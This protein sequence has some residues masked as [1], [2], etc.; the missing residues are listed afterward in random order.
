M[1][2]NFLLI[3]AITLFLASGCATIKEDNSHKSKNPAI[4]RLNKQFIGFEHGM[5]IGGWLTNYKRFNVL[6][7]K[8]KLNLSPGDYEHFETYITRNDVQNIASFGMDH[9]RLGF[10]QIVL[11]EKP[12]VYRERTFRLIDNFISWCREYKIN[13]VLN[14][15]KAIGNYC[16]IPEPVSLMDDPELQ[17]RFIALWLEFERR[18]H[19]NN[20]IVF[21]L[22]NEVRNVNPKLWNSLAERTIQTIRKVNPTRKIVI[23]STAWNSCST[24]KDLQIFDDEN[25]IYTFHIYEPFEFTHQRG[26]LQAAPL[27]Y[28]R[29]MA[30]PSDIAP[31]REFKKFVGNSD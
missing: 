16:D 14:L 7:D 6:P 27:Y 10:D 24:L 17:K 22:M 8:W 31:Y 5:G 11:E 28:N 30:Y 29:K 21:E 20:S 4:P 3:S 13:V 12:Y 25:V 9:I 26:V 18:Y 1:N 23:G 15:H 2:H 19:D